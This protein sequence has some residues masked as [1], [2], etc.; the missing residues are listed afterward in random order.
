MFAYWPGKISAGTTSDHISAFWDVLPT[1]AEFTGEPVNGPTD[2]VSMLPT[3][4]G[5][6][7]KQRKHEYLYWENYAGRASRAVRM[8]NW[9]AVVPLMQ[10]GEEIELYNLES[11]EFEAEDVADQYPEVMDQIKK[12]MDE[13]HTPSPLY[14]IRFD[15]NFNAT[16]AC[17]INGVE[18]RGNGSK[19]SEKSSPKK[20]RAEKG[21]KKAA[22]AVKPAPVTKTAPAGKHEARQWA[23]GSDKEVAGT[24]VRIFIN[25]KKKKMVVLRAPDGKEFK[26]GSRSMTAEDRAYLKSIQAD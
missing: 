25:P 5:E 15:K 14:D 20:K 7:E 16:E 21:E 6:P 8:G 2:G 9:K 19:S 11:D 24:F 12:I 17:R 13:A 22:P 10:K 1:M 4:L 18:I 23:A 26:L 3:L